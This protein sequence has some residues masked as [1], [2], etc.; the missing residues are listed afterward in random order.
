MEAPSITAKG[1]RQFPGQ[2]ADFTIVDNTAR[3]RLRVV[4]CGGGR[5]RRGP[6]L[7]WKSQRPPLRAHTSPRPTWRL[8]YCGKYSAQPRARCTPVATARGAR[9]MFHYTYTPRPRARRAKRITMFARH[10]RAR[11]ARDGLRYVRAKTARE[12]IYDMYTPRPR[13]ERA[14]WIT[15]LER[16]DRARSARNVLR[17]LHA[18]TAREAHETVYT[19]YTPRPRA[20]RAR[21][22]FGIY[23]PRPRAKHAKSATMFTRYDRARSARD[24]LQY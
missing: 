8:F 18:T 12:A 15:I 14:K 13:E 11:R 20:K 24:G 2:H 6:K 9:E 16:H 17:Y 21:H 3:A 1:A 7:T 4:R 23:A 10:D 5:A 19:M 22:V